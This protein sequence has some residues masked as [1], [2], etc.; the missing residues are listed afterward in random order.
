MKAFEYGDEEIGGKDLAFAVASMLIGVGILTLPRQL[1]ESTK[2][3]GWM[4]ITIAGVFF[5]FFGWFTA[6]LASRFPKKTFL[7]YTAAI[8]TKP[9]AIFLSLV[10]GLTFLFLVSFEVRA[11]GNITKLYFFDRTPVE[12]ITLVYL[13]VVIY[14]VAGSRA[15][16]FRLNIMFLPIVLFVT[17]LVQ[18]FNLHLFE[19]N[20]LKPFFQAGIAG[21]AQGALE[22]VFSLSGYVIVLFYIAL[23]NKPQQGPKMTV[24]GMLIPFA[25]Y[26]FIITFVIGVFGHFSAAN[27]V[28]PT[29]EIAKEVEVPGGFFERFESVFFMVWIMTIF[30]TTAMAYDVALIA[31]SSVF[32]KVKK[33]TWIF[34]LSPILYIIAMTPQDAIELDTMGAWLSYCISVFSTIIPALLLLVASIRGV[35]GHA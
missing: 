17:L 4:S 15:A 14:A 5:I 21:V 9:V 11:L 1:A 16:L 28:Y 33:M 13:L 18:F 34:V 20:N 30:N 25:L 7:D 24:I 32:K 8:A 6:K 22:T 2:V 3:N 10:L 35:K 31:L 27:I 23:M 12:V 26:L 19:M 29:I